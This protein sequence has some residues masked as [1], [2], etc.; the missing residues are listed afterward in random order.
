MLFFGFNL[1]FFLYI[2]LAPPKKKKIIPL[3]LTPA[4]QLENLGYTPVDSAMFIQKKKK[5]T[6]KSNQF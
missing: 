4:P 1:I 3:P 6:D 5:K 2:F